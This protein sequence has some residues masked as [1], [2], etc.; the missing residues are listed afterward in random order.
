MGGPAAIEWLPGFERI[1][2]NDAGTW[3]TGDSPSPKIVLHRT[4]GAS[5]A[6]AV[7]A[8]RAHN[9][10]PHMTV[11]MGRRQRVQHSSLKHPARSLRNTSAPGQTGRDRYVYQIEIVGFSKFSDRDSDAELAW[12][13]REVLAPLA[14]ATGTKLETS[15]TFYGDGCG[16]TLATES[17][18]QR[19]TPAAYDRY[20]GV[21]AHQHVPE[22][23]HWDVGAFRI[24]VALD[25]ARHALHPDPNAGR[26]WETFAG[27]GTTDIGVYA[28]GGLD[29]EVSQ[30]QILIGHPVTHR[31]EKRDAD[32]IAKLKTAAKWVD[33]DEPKHNRTSGV[34]PAF[35]QALEGLHGAKG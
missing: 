9:S 22:N 4:E 12:L 17:A 16:W 3:A 1:P 29:N 10:W 11:D 13:G 14:K 8:Y 34:T 35:H 31:Y 5:I 30:V 32:A 21:L 18:R 7:G 27:V 23:T 19:L 24:A 15:V 28:A 26:H 2:G 33:P 25:A 6:G 20:E